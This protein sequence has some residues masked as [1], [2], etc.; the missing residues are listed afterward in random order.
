ME[1]AT[2]SALSARQPH[3]KPIDVSYATN[4]AAVWSAA[5]IA[6]LLT[7]FGA[8]K[9]LWPTPPALTVESPHAVQVISIPA[10]RS[11]APTALSAV[12]AQ[13]ELAAPQSMLGFY[14]PLQPVL[15]DRIE[16]SKPLMADHQVAS[17]AE[18]SLE[19]NPMPTV[20]DDPTLRIGRDPKAMLQ[21]FSA[22][23]WP[24]ND[25]SKST[26]EMLS[27]LESHSVELDLLS[28]SSIVKMVPN[29]TRN[30]RGQPN[31]EFIFADSGEIPDVTSR[32]P[33]LSGLPF[34]RGSAC[35]KSAVEAEEIDRIS[36]ELHRFTDG[37][38]LGAESN[39]SFDVS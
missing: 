37:V 30:R 5:G 39:S 3:S 22:I 8:A 27:A 18:A 7:A 15:H 6:L 23:N 19:T 34:R 32:H 2:M 29:G 12:S 9:M 26:K 10:L 38:L 35:R 20:L 13:I 11:D 1:V 14:A 28:L 21:A 24:D 25:Y 33:E 17:S 4:W 36:T 31:V 16:S